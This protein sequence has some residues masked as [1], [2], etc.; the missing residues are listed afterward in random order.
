M[1][2]L[3]LPQKLAYEKNYVHEKILRR[4]NYRRNFV[5]NLPPEKRKENM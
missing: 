5:K 3:Q 2:K 1:K 4:R